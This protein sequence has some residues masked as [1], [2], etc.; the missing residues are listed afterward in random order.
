MKKNNFTTESFCS[1]IEK[2]VAETVKFSFTNAKICFEMKEAVFNKYGEFSKE[3]LTSVRIQSYI[4]EHL[5]RPNWPPELENYHIFLFETTANIEN[6]DKDFQEKLLIF[7]NYI[8]NTMQSSTF[9]RTELGIN[10]NYIAQL[11]LIILQVNR[12]LTN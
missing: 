4:I 11:V 6:I 3:I 12:L 5:I 8:E 9:F 1:V 10:F 2:Y 7:K